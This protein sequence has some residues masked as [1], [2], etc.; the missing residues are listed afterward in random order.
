MTRSVADAAVMLRA[1][2]GFDP[3]DPTTRRETVRDYLDIIY[4]DITG[5]RI[6]VD[7]AYCTEGTESE[8]SQ[9]VFGDGQRA[10]RL[11]GKYSRGESVG[12]QR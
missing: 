5:L 9:A 11:G 8:V 4:N 6:G 2:A 10:A 3:N 7:E 12:H 1:I